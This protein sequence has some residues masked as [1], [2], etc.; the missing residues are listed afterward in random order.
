MVQ[1]CWGGITII[2]VIKKQQQ[3]G[4]AVFAWPQSQ[5]PMHYLLVTKEQS[6]FTV[7]KYGRN[8]RK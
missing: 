4:E 2:T 6:D 8:H 5:H 7:E 3:F 1:F